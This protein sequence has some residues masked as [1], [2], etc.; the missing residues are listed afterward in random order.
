VLPAALWCRARD[1]GTRATSAVPVSVAERRRPLLTA[2][3]LLPHIHKDG[4]CNGE[5]LS[6][7]VPAPDLSG[8]S[9]RGCRAAVLQ[10]LDLFLGTTLTGELRAACIATRAAQRPQVRG[11]ARLSALAP[12]LTAPL[13]TLALFLSDLAEHDA[14]ETARGC[15]QLHG[16]RL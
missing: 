5:T 10:W 3:G 1:V 15:L 12:A 13:T 14:A 11:A 4:P 9:R 7:N 8:K 16:C 6:W 2:A